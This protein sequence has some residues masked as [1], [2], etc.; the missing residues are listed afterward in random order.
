MKYKDNS[1]ICG[2]MTSPQSKHTGLWLHLAAWAVIFGLPLFVPGGR[3]PVI[4]MQEYVRFLVGPLS[5]I[6]VFYI[7]FFLLIDRY[8]FT[9]RVGRF[10]LTNVL[11]VAGVMLAVHLFFRFGTPPRVHHPPMERPW[12]DEMFFFLRNAMLYMLVVGVSVA[13][14][15]TGQ[16]Y[17]AENIR[18]ELERS[19]SEAELQNLKSQLNPHFLFNTLNNIYSLIQLDPDRAQQTVHD[20]SRL[21]RYVLYDSSQP[22]VPLKAEI[23]FLSNYIELMRIRLP[24][25]VRLEVSMPENPSRTPVAPL[26]FISLI[27]NAFKHG[28]S[29][30]HPSSIDIDI[31]EEGGT[32]A[33]RIE[34]SF[35]PK[36]G[37]DRSG[38]GIGL[39]NLCRRLEM[40]YPG[41]YEMEYGQQGDTYKTMLRIKLAD[42]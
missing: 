13:I 8:L 12:Q 23:D 19:R 20:L 41:R 16:W 28:V 32:L 39:V 18:R 37:D 40:I 4:N 42:R 35:F 34:N 5:F 25:H 24:H 11:L 17:R 27:E 21:L 26:L 22:L 38:S 30:D 31:R 7:N 9:Q 29:N 6:A 1:Y 33:C 14:R 15:M 3:E 36:S 10:L 2:R